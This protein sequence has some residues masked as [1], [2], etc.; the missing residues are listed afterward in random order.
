MSKYNY[1]KKINRNY[2]LRFKWFI[3]MD[4]EGRKVTQKL[5]INFIILGLNKY[6]ASMK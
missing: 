4:H 2:C 3:I 1:L 5:L 6:K